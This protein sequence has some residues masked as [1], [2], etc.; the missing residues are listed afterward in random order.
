MCVHERES[1]HEWYDHLFLFTWWPKKRTVHFFNI[2]KT[3][4]SKTRKYSWGGWGGIL[5]RGIPDPHT[6]PTA[7]KRK[8]GIYSTDSQ[9]RRSETAK[10][11]SYHRLH[12][13]KRPLCCAQLLA[14]VAFLVRRNRQKLKRW[15]NDS[16]TNRNGRTNSKTSTAGCSKLTAKY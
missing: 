16:K 12:F 5:A 9:L 7:M 6:Q 8:V 1:L 2:S 3:T 14:T 10:F 11:A 13:P 4:N 15:A